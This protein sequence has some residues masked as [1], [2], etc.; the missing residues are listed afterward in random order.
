MLKGISTFFS[1]FSLKQRLYWGFFA[2]LMLVGLSI[3]LVIFNFS[4]FNQANDWLSQTNLLIQH[5]EEVLDEM[6]DMEANATDYVLTGNEKYLTHYQRAHTSFNHNFKLLLQ[7][8]N[9]N[10]PPKNSFRKLE[11]AANKQI[12]LTQK[13]IITRQ[14]IGA[15]AAIIAMQSDTPNMYMDNFRTT[16]LAFEREEKEL[17]KIRQQKQES[18]QLSSQI[19]FIALILLMLA[20]L[21]ISFKSI[22]NN[23]K[24]RITAEENLQVE[25]QLLQ[26]II[27]NTS[28]LVFIK[29]KTGKYLLANKQ[30]TDVFNIPAA[31]VTEKSDADLFPSDTALKLR[32]TDNKV[33]TTGIPM[34]LEE[35]VPI[36]GKAHTYLSIKFP[37]RDRDGNIYALC[38][39]STDI[40][41]RKQHE[42][43]IL[44]LNTQLET[45]NQRLHNINKELEAFTYTVSHD[46]RAPLRAINGFASL[47][48]RQSEEK[49]FDADTMRIMTMMRENAAQMG[50]LIDDLLAFSKLGR[51]KP[52]FQLTDMKEVANAVAAQLTYENSPSKILLNIKHIE[53]AICDSSLIKQV[54]INLVSNAIKYSSQKPKQFIEIGSTNNN[55]EIIYYVKD[56]GAGFDMKYYNKLF[57]IFQ[58]LHSSMEF[59]G[60]G[61]GLAIVNRIVKRHSG[62]VW[63]ESTLGEGATFYF[64]LPAQPRLSDV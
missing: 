10:F 59:E 63:A 49:N 33:L 23:L 44:S 26:N 21:V 2:L 34:E 1:D 22:A 35:I 37:L 42:S 13:L 61:V 32:K 16:L 24:Q 7:L 41:E 43:Q 48:Q 25:K 64:S 45:N 56:N 12:E 27:D 52:N 51:Y 36:Q 58:R 8:N 15:K 9:K 39:M 3:A 46:L 18:W 40:T 14:N 30:F 11:I 5:T 38:G 54:W 53:P 57:G 17:L 28:T 62:K 4:K 19:A 55:G 20:V 47:L 31:A 6:L 50:Q 29:D 60:T